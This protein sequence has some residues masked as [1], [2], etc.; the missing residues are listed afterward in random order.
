MI[1]NHE[2]ATKI[3]YVDDSNS[4]IPSSISIEKDFVEY[5]VNLNNQKF[6]MTNDDSAKNNAYGLT[7]LLKVSHF[8]SIY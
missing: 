7:I 2:N 8:F 4:T 3:K 6:N 5:S 1:L